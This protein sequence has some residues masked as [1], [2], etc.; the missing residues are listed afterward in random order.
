MDIEYIKN[1][2]YFIPNIVLPPSEQQSIGKYGRMRMDYLKEH[3]PII[4]NQLILSGKLYNHLIEIEQI[5]QERLDRM[6]PQMKGEEGV[7]EALKA[8]DQMKWVRKMN[9]IRN[10]AEEMIL[11]DL[12]YN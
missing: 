7:S 12:I 8:A 3:R 6:I 9:N 10:R 4:Y 5:C 11:N 1:G 2:D